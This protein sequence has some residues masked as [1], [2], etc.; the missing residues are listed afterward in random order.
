MYYSN[1]LLIFIIPQF[2]TKQ[3]YFHYL[4]RNKQSIYDRRELKK[5]QTA[6]CNF[7]PM[8]KSI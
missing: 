8:L 1:K 7:I 5:A 4:R 3:A 6:I 2:N